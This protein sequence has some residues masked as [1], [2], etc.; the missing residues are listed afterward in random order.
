MKLLFAFAILS[1][2]SFAHAV[3]SSKKELMMDVSKIPSFSCSVEVVD[4]E[5]LKHFGSC[6]GSLISPNTVLTAYHCQ[7]IPEMYRAN[8]RPLAYR[9]QCGAEERISDHVIIYGD[10]GS[11]EAGYKPPR[12]NGAYD[13]MIIKLEENFLNAKSALLPSSAQAAVALMTNSQK[14]FISGFGFGYDTKTSTKEHR[15]LQV[16]PGLGR[17]DKDEFSLGDH[18]FTRPGDSGGGAYCQNSSGD[19]VLIGLLR[20]G[21]MDLTKPSRASLV[22]DPILDWINYE[23]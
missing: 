9:V 23:L 14:C 5:N 7:W 8:G 2:F 10:T 20:S 15:G 1:Y 16:F 6:S 4:A 21:P 22:V 18:A 19:F 12:G 17:N 13:N 3:D 11:S